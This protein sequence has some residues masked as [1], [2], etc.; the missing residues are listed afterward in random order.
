MS[1]ENEGSTRQNVFCV[2]LSLVRSSEKKLLSAKGIRK[3]PTN[4]IKTKNY[5]AYL[6]DDLLRKVPLR[7]IEG[8]L[9]EFC[10]Y[11]E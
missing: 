6:L 9:E 4:V 1:A 3:F 8:S 10:E 11:S 7:P 5:V 2:S